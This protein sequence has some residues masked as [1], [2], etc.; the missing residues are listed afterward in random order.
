MSD[1]EN[2]SPKRPISISTEEFDRKVEAGEDIDDYLDWENA[3]AVMPGEFS[4]ETMLALQAQ[5]DRGSLHEK[6]TDAA[7]LQ[8]SLP[9]WAREQLQSEAAQQGISWEELAQFLILRQLK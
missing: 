8:V 9:G 4:A 2:Q 7:F 1:L 6:G 3:V 5:E